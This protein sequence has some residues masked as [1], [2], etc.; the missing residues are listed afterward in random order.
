MSAGRGGSRFGSQNHLGR[1]WKVWL[2]DGS[3]KGASSRP[4]RWASSASGNSGKC[5]TKPKIREFLETRGCTATSIEVLERTVKP[6]SDSSVM[7][8]TAVGRTTNH[9]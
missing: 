3:R 2:R 7:R 9:H 5:S 6:N 4:E 1:K 8:W